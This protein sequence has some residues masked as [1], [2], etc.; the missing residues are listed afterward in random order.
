MPDVNTSSR[1]YKIQAVIHNSMLS[2]HCEHVAVP[3]A[4][5]LWQIC[6]ELSSSPHLPECGLCHISQKPG[7]MDVYDGSGGYHDKNVDNH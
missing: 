1:I 7:R 4:V 2:N 3:Q 5:E 6:L